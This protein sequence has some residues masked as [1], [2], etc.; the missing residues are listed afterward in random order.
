MAR[1]LIGGFGYTRVGD[2]WNKSLV[3]LI[4]DAA[5]SASNSY[6][7]PKID[8]I[9]VSNMFSELSSSQ[10]NLGTIIAEGLLSDGVGALRVEGA[11]CSGGLAVELATSMVR[12]GARDAVLVAGGEKIRDLAPGYAPLAISLGESAEY[13]QFIG[14]TLPALYGMLTRLYMNEYDISRESL[15]AFPVLAH[16]NAASA[17]HAMFRKKISHEDVARSALVSDPIRLLDSAS[18]GDGAAAVI[19]VRDDLPKKRR[20]AVEIVGSS[21]ATGTN[22]FYSRRDM[23]D[24]T[25]TRTATKDVMKKS[26]I[27]LDKIDFVEVHDSFSIAAAL[28]LEAMGLS[29]R[30]LA[31]KDAMNGVFDKKGRLPIN[32]FGGLKARGNP[33]GA[34]GIYQLIEAY[35]QLCDKAGAN[36]LSGVRTGLVHSMAGVDSVAAV[37]VL[38]RT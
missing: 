15:S 36:Q 10:L 14:C 29:K 23:L 25:S 35:L 33:V 5:S 3:D 17:Q 24:F 11:D 20:E 13:T 16:A 34:T 4:L 8:Q 18:L 7:G 30:G 2:H 32:S 6:K 27:S 38:R 12:S 19:I 26:G 21:V 9:I 37:H 22:S 31:T 1:A 28:S